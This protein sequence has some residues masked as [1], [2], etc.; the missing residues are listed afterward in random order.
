MFLQHDCQEFL[1]LLLDTL[2]EQLSHHDPE[3]DKA[4]A[5][6]QVGFIL[7]LTINRYEIYGTKIKNYIFYVI[8]DRIML[9][10]RESLQVLTVTVIQP[11]LTVQ[12]SL[13]DPALTALD[14][15]W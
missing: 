3:L 12:N 8:F 4:A 10:L 13:I 9:Y 7:L 14:R 15:L 2:H 11:P 5:A 6:P 1:A